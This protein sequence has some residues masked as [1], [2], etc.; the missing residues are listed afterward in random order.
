MASRR[1]ITPALLRQ[2]LTYEPATGSLFWRFRPRALFA[3]ERSFLTW[4]TRFS[5]KAAGCTDGHGYLRVAVLGQP[6]SAHRIAWALT[7]G[8]WPDQIDHI[9]HNRTDN[10]LANLRAVSCLGN[11]MNQGKSKRNTSG[12]TGV[13]WNNATRKWRAYIHSK[14]T[15]THIGLFDN[16]GAA[17]VARR[18]A[19]KALGF[20]PNHG[21]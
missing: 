9:N 5:G 17:T 12:I 6:F 13:S 16:L 4:N 21:S 19:E 3:T 18:Q 20:H 8:E 1:D 14:G 7:H 10:R 15:Y 2:L 11:R